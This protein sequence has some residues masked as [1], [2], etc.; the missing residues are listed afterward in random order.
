MKA[1]IKDSNNWKIVIAG[2]PLKHD[3]YEIV[4]S[5]GHKFITASKFDYL[6]TRL[7]CHTCK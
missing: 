7:F 5:C 6:K 3:K 2:R 1:N 4:L